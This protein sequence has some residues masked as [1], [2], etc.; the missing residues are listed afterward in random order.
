MSTGKAIE[1]RHDSYTIHEIPVTLLPFEV[2]LRA[3]SISHLL[4]WI[5]WLLHMMTLFAL[6][7][8]TQQDAS[9]MPWRIWIAALSEL[10]LA[11][12]AVVVAS[13]IGLALCTGKAAHPRPSYQLHGRVAPSVD[14]MITACGE[15]VDIVIN[16]VAAAAAQDYPP[17]Q[18]RVFVL[19]DGHDAD[20]RHAVDR[21]NLRLNRVAG[22]PVIY[23]SRTVMP[24][25][26]SHFKS[27][28][29]RFG[30]EQSQRLGEGSMLLA[31]LDADMIPEPSWLRE[32]VPHLLLNED[33]A[34]ACGPQVR[35]DHTQH[36]KIPTPPQ[37]PFP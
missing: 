9:H 4:S 12:P 8:Q 11:I 22:P 30:I 27:G 10:L 3:F 13:T 23:L 18:L 26:Q 25:Q 17:E 33:V 32:M 34:M 2:Y 21:L 19:D 7:Y 5:L 24:G 29:L 36:S 28:N 1:I 6:A 14:I 31:G 16:T 35:H 37:V 20:L 15:P